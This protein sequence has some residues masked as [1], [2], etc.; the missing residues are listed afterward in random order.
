MKLHYQRIYSKHLLTHLDIS[1]S[2]KPL[3]LTK[4][5]GPAWCDL[6]RMEMGRALSALRSIHPS[7]APSPGGHSGAPPARPPR[8]AS[9]RLASGLLLSEAPCWACCPH[10][11]RSLH[12]KQKQQ[13][14]QSTEVSVFQV[15]QRTDLSL[16]ICAKF[17]TKYALLKMS[18]YSWGVVINQLA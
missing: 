3:H 7:I 15:G 11:R 13:G 16:C 17:L 9:P 5:S 8:L 18:H 14:T 4:N 12:G 2:V 10:Q 6:T 1:I